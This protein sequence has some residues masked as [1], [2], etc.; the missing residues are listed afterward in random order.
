MQ[1]LE[2][3]GLAHE[4]DGKLH[5]EQYEFELFDD[6]IEEKKQVMMLDET[7]LL[8]QLEDMQLSLEDVGKLQDELHDEELF[9]KKLDDS[10]LCDFVEEQLKLLLVF[11][12]LLDEELKKLQ[13]EQGPSKDDVGEI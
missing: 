5:D 4:D 12:K 6:K 1:L 9:D 3:Q 10:L 13:E 11:E 7:Q 8:L 2:E